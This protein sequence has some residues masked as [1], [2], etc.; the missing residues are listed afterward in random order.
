M[1][2]STVLRSSP[3]CA[4]GVGSTS[5]SS[6]SHRARVAVRASA[7]GGGREKSETI[8]GLV[9]EPMKEVQMQLK[10]QAERGGLNDPTHSLVRMHYS[11]KAESAVN[12]QI[13]I[14]YN[15]SYVYHSMSAYFD[16]DNVS[17][18][19]FAKYFR[20][21]SLE[22][23]GH[24]QKLIDFQNTRGGRVRLLAL[25]PPETEFTE[26]SRGDA[27]YAM[28]LSLSLERLNYDKLLHLWDVMEEEADAQ[29]SHF[30]EY[31]L[32]EQ[33]ADIKETADYVSQLRRVGKGHG[34]WHFDHELY[35]KEVRYMAYAGSDAG[36]NGA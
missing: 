29:A 22:E 17:L 3:V 30:I 2:V 5:T 24:A 10:D 28:E 8:T 11:P 14:E 25:V 4:S 6:S 32:E 23:R 26:D 16:R 27:L 1:I 13:N 9:F 20:D 34:V 18:P 36:S 7:R 12:E 31:M 15:I 33:A 19:G 21:Q 35:E